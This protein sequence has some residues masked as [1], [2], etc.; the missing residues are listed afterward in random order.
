MTMTL[1]WT[2]LDN[3]VASGRGLHLPLPLPLPVPPPPP[4]P[5][6][7]PQDPPLRGAGHP[8]RAR[9]PTTVRY[10]MEFRPRLTQT[11]C[12]GI[13]KEPCRNCVERGPTRT[14]HGNNCSFFAHFHTVSFTCSDVGPL[15]R[16]W[17]EA[18]TQFPNIFFDN[19]FRRTDFPKHFRLKFRRCGP[20]SFAGTILL[21]TPKLR[22]ASM[23]SSS[24]SWANVT[25]QV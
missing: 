3:D 20:P 4:L 22:M 18:K 11:S 7:P 15:F 6:L 10:C 12:G 23:A 5:P 8:F 19:V 2:N 16:P 13:F 17:T 21:H 9:D 1:S 24:E 14:P 25:R